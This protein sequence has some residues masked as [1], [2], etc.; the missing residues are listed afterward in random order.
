[1][2]PVEFTASEVDLLGRLLRGERRYGP[3]RAATHLVAMRMATW[4]EPDGVLELTDLGH[5]AA[6]TLWPDIL[7][8]VGPGTAAPRAQYAAEPRL[9]RQLCIADL[10]GSQSHGD[11][12]TCLGR[13]LGDDHAAAVVLDHYPRGRGL[14]HASP[15]ALESAG[16]RPRD[17]ALL[18]HAF[19][20]ARAA[21]R[22]QGSEDS[23]VVETAAQMADLVQ[24]LEGVDHLEVEHLWVAS[25][26]ARRR[27]IEVRVTAKGSLTR[28][29]AHMRDIFTPLLR[30]RAAAFFL[31]HNHPSGDLEASDHDIRLAQRVQAQARLFEIDMVDALIV[32]PGGGHLS[33]VERELL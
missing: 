5:A 4:V 19:E 6:L 20:L 31:V 18:V 28:V 22:T 24:Q 26:D 17:A 29:E 16:L 12:R 2:P 1:M 10:E 23:P 8:L 9:S 25:L 32:A 27:L 30:A 15:E 14:P 7:P 33:F 13:L 11:L 3:A 21:S